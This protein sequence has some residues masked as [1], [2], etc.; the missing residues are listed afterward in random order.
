MRNTASGYMCRFK[1]EAR[2]RISGS[3]F[4]YPKLPFYS[5]GDDA[6]QFYSIGGGCSCLC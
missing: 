1:T 6:D 3:K 4:T 2:D 5:L